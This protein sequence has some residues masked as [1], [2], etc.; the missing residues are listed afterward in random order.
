MNIQPSLTNERSFAAYQFSI[1][2]IRALQDSFWAKLTRRNSRL[3]AFP[4]HARR[5]HPNR[6][7]IG[8]KDIHLDQIIGTLNR[9]SDFDNKFRPL[10]KHLLNRW[11]NIFVELDP[12]GWEPILVHK[13][14]ERYY[15][16]DGHHRVSV[17]RSL[18]MLFIQAKV[19]EYPAKQ[20]RT[21][22][23][24]QARCPQKSP[25]K[26]AQRVVG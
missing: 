14:G 1:L 13:I 3:A 20:Q 9:G 16:E 17:A 25:V 12:D 22:T 21:V 15:V 5:D 18:G 10:E 2:R 4:E 24:E 7:L 23:C 26:A 8:V 11:V 6:K 19:W